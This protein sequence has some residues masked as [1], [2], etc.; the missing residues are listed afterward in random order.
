MNSRPT[1]HVFDVGAGVNGDNVTVLNTQVVTDHTVQT[2]AP[3]IEV[4]I[5]KDDEYGVLSL[6]ASDENGVATEQLESVHGVV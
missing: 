3:V 2:T 1:T 4:I 5:A 6:L